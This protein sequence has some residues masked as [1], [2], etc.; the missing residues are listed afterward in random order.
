MHH[1]KT[2]WWKIKPT[3]DTSQSG[4]G[5]IINHLISEYSCEQFLVDVGAH[6]GTSL[7][8]SYP[9][10]KAGWRAILI[11]PNPVVFAKLQKAYSGRSDVTCLQIACSNSSG[12]TDLFFGS[13]GENGFFSTLCR[14]ENQWFSK[15]R[16]QSSTRIRTETLTNILSQYKAPSAFGLLLVD[17]EGFDFEV[18]DGLDFSQFRPRIIV[19]EEYEWDIDKHAA[20]YSLLVKNRYSLVQKIGFNTIW[21]DR[22]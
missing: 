5:V 14:D 17:T 8:N 16:S 12:Y 7:S 18:L 19:T 9:L 6:D 1:L 10:V 21:L 22:S 13:D 3:H 15:A 20:K 4:E 2:L 11:E